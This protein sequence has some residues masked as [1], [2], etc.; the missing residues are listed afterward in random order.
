MSVMAAGSTHFGLLSSEQKA[1]SPL[2]KIGKNTSSNKR[3]NFPE[4]RED[5]EKNGKS[6]YR[7]GL[8]KSRQPTV[9]F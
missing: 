5:G 8:I 6:N 1:G 9:Y 7:N 3:S 4:R 2:K